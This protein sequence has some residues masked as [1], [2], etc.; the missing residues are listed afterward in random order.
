MDLAIPSGVAVVVPVQEAMKVLIAFE[1]L[2]WVMEQGKCLVRRG[3]CGR[4]RW[5]REL[6]GVDLT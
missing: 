4:C 1:P 5:Y 3:D 2:G 6:F